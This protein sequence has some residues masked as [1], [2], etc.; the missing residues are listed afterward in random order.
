MKK[1]IYLLSS[2]SLERGQNTLVFNDGHNKRYIPVTD[3]GSIW[4]CGELDLNKRVLEFLS[5][6]H[7]SLHFLNF[8][9]N[10]IGSYMPRR[11]Y[12]SGTIVLKQAETYLDSKK[13]LKLA[14]KIVEGSLKNI[15]VVLEYYISRGI[16][17]AYERD[18]ID[19][20][21][22]QD[23]T[24]VEELMGNEGNARSTYYSTFDK[25]L[26][27]NPSFT[28]EKRTRMPPTNPV[29]ALLSFGN[30][31]LYGTV[32][33]EIYHTHLDPR[34]GFLHSTNGR[35]FSLNLDV[36][37]I[38]KPLF[39]DRTIMSLINRSAITGADFMKE[40][41]GV[42]LNEPG[43]KKFLSEFEGKLATTINNRTL[44]RKVSYA[45]LIRFELYKIEKHILD[46]KPYTPFVMRW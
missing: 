19:T 46:D 5:S 39:V 23:C 15:T 31:L 24:S 11:V 25:I 43:R 14:Q 30:S 20:L 35:K 32:L 3:V 41:A 33:N 22:F 34:I 12:N 27:N 21:A 4:V 10:Y 16:D 28:F 45:E 26:G 1:R 6:N 36:S 13:R 18:V 29:N 17:L 42:Y 44:G 8:Y 2:G 38:F 7:I 9:G 40:L 37:E